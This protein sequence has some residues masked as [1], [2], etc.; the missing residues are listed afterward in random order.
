MNFVS[1]FV[2]LITFLAVGNV[3]VILGTTLMIGAHFALK[4]G[5]ALIRPL[6]IG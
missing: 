2:A 3:D 5:A 6:C 4:Y 1:N